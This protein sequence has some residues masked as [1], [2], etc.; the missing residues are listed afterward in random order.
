MLTTMFTGCSSDNEASLGL[1]S[2][3]A[4]TAVTM[5]TL[6]RDL[7][8][9]LENGRDTSYLITLPGSAFPMHIDQLRNEVYNTDSLPLGTL[10]NKIVFS[11]FTTDGSILLRSLSGSDTLYATSDTVDFTTPRTFT[12]YA[13]DGTGSRSYTVK[14]NVHQVDPESY[15][16]LADGEANRDIAAMSGMKLIANGSTLYLW[17][18]SSGTPVLM[19]RS[20]STG[21]QWMY[22]EP[23]GANDIDL[24]SITLFNGAFYA[25]GNGALLRSTDGLTWETL[26][27]G[28]TPTAMFGAS[29][30]EIYAST[31][32][33][34][35]SSS[36]G[37][38][39]TPCTID[40]SSSLLPQKDVVS[41]T[42]AAITNANIENVITVGYVDT[43]SV[44]WK[45]EVDLTG[46]ETNP[47]SYFPYTEENTKAL[48]YMHGLSL[49]KYENSLYAA[50]LRHGVPAVFESADGGRTW[51]TPET[52]TI[53]PAAIGSPTEMYLAAGSGSTI[54]LVCAGTGQL[55][56][57][58]LNRLN[59][60]E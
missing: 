53:L 33:G 57:G 20:A 11:T 9:K 32:N 52:E 17:G 25:T 5:G 42:Q 30:M 58:Y 24:Q 49:I 6:Y 12:V 51:I 14:V 8:T 18:M 45:K 27:P 38:T 46:T 16:W 10:V 28:F 54:W 60:E 26:S 34:V 13:A 36:D 4:I 56:R 43:V 41:V 31:A 35:Y 23:T 15:T 22:S 21:A 50:G 1:T 47:W 29:G 37:S 3:C 40:A 19:T 59:V 2:D 39:W 55:W 7:H 48:P 44:V